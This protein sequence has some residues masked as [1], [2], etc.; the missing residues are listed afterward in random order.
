LR[1]RKNEQSAWRESVREVIEDTNQAFTRFAE[2]LYSELSKR[3]ETDTELADF[4]QN[5]LRFIVGRSDSLLLLLQAGRMWDAEILIRPIMEATFRIL[6]VCHCDERERRV[7]LHEFWTDLAEINWLR[8]SER[9]K[10]ILAR[11]PDKHDFARAFK[12]LILEQ[13]EED[14]IRKKWPKRKRQ[15]LEQKW[16]FTEILAELERQMSGTLN[17]GFVRGI[18]HS[19][20]QSSHLIHADETAFGLFWDRQARSPDERKKLVVA[21]ACRLLS[22]ILSYLMANWVALSRVFCFDRAPFDNLRK[23]TKRLFKVFDAAQ[24][25]FWQTQ[26]QP[27]APSS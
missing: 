7:R 12:L 10:T 26:Q 13:K 3:R 21:H 18:L 14:E 16:S 6:F 20:G 15:A 1:R 23:A 2:L 4:A 8:H 11:A 9:A 5:S 27:T 22:D 24:A 17:T 19:Y 25:E